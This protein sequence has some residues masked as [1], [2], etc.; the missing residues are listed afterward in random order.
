MSRVEGNPYLSLN[1]NSSELHIGDVRISGVRLTDER[2]DDAVAGFTLQIDEL[3]IQGQNIADIQLIA[4]IRKE[5]QLFELT[6]VNRDSEIDLTLS[7]AFDDWYSAG[8]SPWRGKVS[9]FSIDLDDEHKLH[10]ERP[11]F[12]ELS[13]SKIAINQFCLA[14]DLLSHLCVDALR[15]SDGHIDLRAEL[16]SVPLAL[17]EHVVDTD[18]SFDQ[19][20]SGSLNWLGNPDSGA[21]GKGELELSS[22]VISR[23]EEPSLAVT[24]GTGQL[25][26]EITDG[27]LLSGTVS[28]PLPGIGGIDARF[29]V[30]KLT[31]P[32]TSDIAG[33]IGLAMTDISSIALFSDLV[34]SASGDL[35]ADLDLSGTLSNPLVTGS[36]VL[37]DGALSY[38]PLGL[39]IDDVDLLGVLT[40]GRAIEL[41]GSFRAGEGHGEIVSSADYRD[42]E[43]AGI[44]FK[45][46]GENLQLVNV[47][48]IQLSANPDIEIAYRE[49]SLNINGS[50]LIPKARIRPANLA[51]NTIS[52]SDDVVIVAGQLQDSPDVPKEESNLKFDGILK[53]DLGSDVVVVLNIA[54]AKLSGGA[55]FDWQGGSLPIVDGRY[56]MSGDIRAFGQVLD[57]AEGGILFANVPANLPYLR[58]RAEREIFGN[59]QI[60]SAGV[61]V[62]GVASHPTIEAY[63]NPVTTE[64]RALT[65]LV[66]GSDFDYEQGIG[67]VDFGTYVAPRLFVS[68][69]VGIFDR[70]NIISARYDLAKGFGIKA[71]SGDNASGVDLNYRLEN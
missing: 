56:D 58:I 21:T 30:L 8:T 19:H 61:L 40:D 13:S 37:D 18:A 11:A 45:I 67:A 39:D 65:L 27:D 15:S 57:I 4:S 70:D 59:S 48:D 38:R 16:S 35:H 54:R 26:F 46:R 49:N 55:V 51:E 31:E 60:K 3:Q 68:Y 42:I 66:T 36:V 47:A 12:V 32:A 69:G 22:G 6:G 17:I 29:K 28:I 53:I 62:D 10:L 25:R 34:D 5:L 52:E 9:S 7:G 50:L 33:H 64:E 20:L 63:T 23:Q 14:D 71:S 24:T 43:T 44:R 2:A 41:S 1:L